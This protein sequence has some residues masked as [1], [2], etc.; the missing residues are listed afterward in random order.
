MPLG[1]NFGD[2]DAETDAVVERE[3]RSVTDV[4]GVS[5]TTSDTL[6]P[7]DKVGVRV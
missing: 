6:L 7:T 4:D 3:A 2:V 1:V 5:E